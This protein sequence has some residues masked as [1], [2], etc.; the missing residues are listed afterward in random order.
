MRF[1]PILF[2][3]ILFYA[4]R[5][6]DSILSGEVEKDDSIRF[7]SILFVVYFISKTWSNC[8]ELNLPHFSSK[9]QRIFVGISRISQDFDENDTKITM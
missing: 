7:D 9:A 5:P 8:K 4:F 2:N 3:S 1:R 6:G